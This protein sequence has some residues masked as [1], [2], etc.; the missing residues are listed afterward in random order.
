[1]DVA[2]LTGSN[3][4]EDGRGVA[5]ADLDRDGRLDLILHNYAT[6]AVLLSGQGPSGNW[7]QLELSG[8]RS[9]RDAVGAVVTVRAS[10]ESQTRQVKVGSGYLSTS[11]PILH[12]GLGGA[13]AVDQ[14]TIRWP[15]GRKEVLSDI[16]ANQRLHIREGGVRQ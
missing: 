14:V 4:I 6:L 5:V 3:R 7:L 1:M 9:N 2:Y 16:P 15:T 10:G 12:F 11:S 13:Q 8:T